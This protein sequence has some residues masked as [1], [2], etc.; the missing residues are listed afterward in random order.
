MKE[1]NCRT[2]VTIETASRQ[3]ARSDPAFLEQVVGLQDDLTLAGIK[4]LSSTEGGQKGIGEVEP[5]VRAVVIGG[6]GLIALFSVAKVWLKQRGD[7]LLRI[8]VTDKS[9]DTKIIR[10]DGKNVSDEAMLAFAED[11]AKRLD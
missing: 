11:M 10:L 6:P 4:I 9:G 5:I 2:E 3:Y 8:S 1:E 7:R